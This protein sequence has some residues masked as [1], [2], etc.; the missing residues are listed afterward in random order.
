MTYGQF[1]ISI[2]TRYEILRGLKAKQAIRQ[3]AIFEDQCLKSQ[4]YPLTDAIVVRASDIFAFLH[5]Q[6][7]LISDADILIAATALSHNLTLITGNVDH[8]IRIPE[9]IIENWKLP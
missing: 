5:N 3:I 1:R 9:L 4:I 8:Y 6:G 7:K 2:I